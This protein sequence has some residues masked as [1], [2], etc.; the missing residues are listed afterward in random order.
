MA[1]NALTERVDFLMQNY[2]AF[3]IARVDQE[4]LVTKKVKGRNKT[5]VHGVSEEDMQWFLIISEVLRLY[6]GTPKYEIFN[7]RYIKKE[8]IVNICLKIGI[9]DGT[10]YNWLNELIFNILMLAAAEGKISSEM[11]LQ[12]INSQIIG[13]GW[14]KK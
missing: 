10:F 13:E 3:R 4:I 14:K 12:S 11:I 2:E 1:F 8:E 6:K 5:V 7:K 9:T